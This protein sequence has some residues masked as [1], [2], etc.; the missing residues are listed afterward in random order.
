MPPKY[1][2]TSSETRR[3]FGASALA[4]A[5]GVVL[6]VVLVASN[7]Y[8]A[9]S[10]CSAPGSV[11]TP[12]HPVCSTPPP[13]SPSTFLAAGTIFSVT[14]GQFES[15]Q[16]QPSDAS[17]ALLNGSFTAPAGVVILV[18][19]P[20]EF[21]NFSR[22]PAVF[23]CAENGECYA[24]GNL[25]VGGVHFTLPLYSDADGG[26]GVAPWY[27]VMQNENTVSATAVTWTTSLVATYVD[28]YA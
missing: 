8:V 3:R 7:A 28:V 14:A 10:Q 22:A 20:G 5:A 17:L 9:W 11:A 4:A 18:M 15:F 13:P 25:T 21:S 2:R 26:T 24:T 16:F 6:G 27:L 1:G 23:P 12:G 19:T